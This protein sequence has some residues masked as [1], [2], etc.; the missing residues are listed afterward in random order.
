MIAL[1]QNMNLIFSPLELIAIVVAIYLTRMLTYDGESSWL[2]GV[3]LIA[4]STLFGIG[5]FHHP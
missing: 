1:G 4:V 5:F 3:L 2:E